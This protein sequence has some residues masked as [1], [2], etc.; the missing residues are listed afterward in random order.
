MRKPHRRPGNFGLSLVRV[1]HNQTRAVHGAAKE[2]YSFEQAAALS[3]TAATQNGWFRIT[4]IP[5]L[6][7]GYTG[8][9]VAKR[10]L[11]KGARVTQP[12]VTRD[13]YRTWALTS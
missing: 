3:A 7:C 10:F 11:A 1:R 12:P 5:I 8:A 2:D 13:G 9:R 6:G 4:D